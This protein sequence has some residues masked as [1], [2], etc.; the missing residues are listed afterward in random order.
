MSVRIREL[1]TGVASC[2]LLVPAGCRKTPTAVVDPE[3]GGEAVANNSTADA[4]CDRA[5]AA[6]ARPRPGTSGDQE[7]PVVLGARFVERDRVQ[8]TFSEALAP[9]AQVNPR[10]FRLSMA[11]STTDYGA[12]YA[13][14]YYYDL[15]GGDNYEPPMVVTSLVGY[16]DRPE[17]LALQL[18][19]P[20]PA[21][22]CND[23][24]ERRSDMASSD[25]ESRARVGVFLHY[26]SRGSVGVRDLVDNPMADM[27][28]E[29]ALH[30]GARHKTLYGSEP[31]MRLD[32]LVEL[33]CPS[34]F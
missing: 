32:L 4:D 33:S 24:N 13:S 7:P 9:T 28:G 11:Y 15:S 16:D 17:V 20:I 1:A 29:W 18:S 26:T 5:P 30:Y 6:P 14:G 22:L 34:S 3:A 25:P 8:L 27:G 12:G 2:V 21:E 19:R 10:Q 23:L 31:I